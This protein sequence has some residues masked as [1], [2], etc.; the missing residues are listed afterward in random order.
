MTIS[1]LNSHEIKKW[2][3]WLLRSYGIRSLPGQT[4]YSVTVDY[5]M[6]LTPLYE[7]MDLEL[8]QERQGDAIMATF[9]IISGIRTIANIWRSLELPPLPVRWAVD[10]AKAKAQII[11]SAANGQIWWGTETLKDPPQMTSILYWF[12][13]TFSFSADAKRA[14]RVDPMVVPMEASLD[15]E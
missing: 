10:L 2:S 13:E 15:L 11:K 4:I 9:E 8:R 7:L 6:I 14:L 1:P 12:P 5:P 3:R